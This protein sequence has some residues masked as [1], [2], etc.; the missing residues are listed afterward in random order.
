M[1]D[2]RRIDRLTYKPHEYFCITLTSPLGTGATGNAHEGIIDL[3]EPSGDSLSLPNIVV[4]FAFRPDERQRL[5]H[6][7]KVYEHSKSIRVTGIPHHFGLFKDVESDTLA[8]VMT[9]G[10]T[11]LLDR[12]PRPDPDVYD[13]PF[14]VSKSERADSIKIL[15]SIHAAGFRHRDI[16]GANLVVNEDGS[17]NIIDFDRA[18]L[19]SRKRTMQLE[20]EHLISVLD[21]DH[22]AVGL[23]FVSR[24]SFRESE[25]PS[26]GPGSSWEK[27][28]I[29]IGSIL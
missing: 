13:P 18:S 28:M 6:E 12:K 23:E 16:R 4:K 10:G 3:M 25:S 22:A 8:L 2:Q 11:C 21:G 29:Q 19:K 20:M 14:T 17:V 5:R 7:F 1:I 15:E 26:A 9:N 24:G 27:R